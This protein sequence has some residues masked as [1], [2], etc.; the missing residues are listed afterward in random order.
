M[1]RRRNPIPYLSR[2]DTTPVGYRKELVILAIVLQKQPSH[3]HGH[4]N[5]ATDAI[6]RCVRHD[7]TKV[8]V[9]VGQD[10]FQ[11]TDTHLEAHTLGFSASRRGSLLQKHR[12][13]VT[14]SQVHDVRHFQV[15]DFVKRGWVWL[16]GYFARKRMGS[17]AFY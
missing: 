9:V 11:R 15:S 17:K 5:L 12:F 14:H 13:R 10:G 4:D 8:I 6:V 2:I 16:G 3:I 7:N 1:A